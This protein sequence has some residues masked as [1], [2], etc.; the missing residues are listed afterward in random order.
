MS[1]WDPEE[2]RYSYHVSPHGVDDLTGIREL[3]DIINRMS[4]DRL[5]AYGFTLRNMDDARDWLNRSPDDWPEATI[6]QIIGPPTSELHINDEEA[7][8][9]LLDGRS[10]H[11]RR[12]DQEI[13]L[14]GQENLSNHALIHPYLAPAASVLAAW[15]DWITFHA[16]GFEVDGRAWILIAERKGGKSTTLAA[17]AEM[18]YRVLAD[19][20][21]V[22]RDGVALAGPRSLDLREKGQFRDITDLGIVGE[23]RR[24][25]L[26]LSSIS[27]ELPV[28]GA[29][30]LSWSDTP[31]IRDAS[32]E[33]RAEL[34]MS[35]LTR[36][37]GSREILELF[38]LPTS[39]ISRPRG[40]IEDTVA[41]IE[42][43]VAQG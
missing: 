24:W 42:K 39:T 25:R 12:A 35:A 7:V 16:G 11:L 27:P 15:R 21:I 13:R 14:V 37:I 29:I 43:V 22:F 3:G 9:P 1:C 4:N 34:L 17:M 8:I 41:L 31:E 40:S 6:V 33:V 18:G 5:G 32:V 36:P 2:L 10:L 20:L 26:R 30:K 19:D 23:R 28:A 38:S